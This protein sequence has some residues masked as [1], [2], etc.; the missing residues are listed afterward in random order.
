MYFI[1]VTPKVLAIGAFGGPKARLR[2][3]L[4]KRPVWHSGSE[5]LYHVSECLWEETYFIYRG[6]VYYRLGLS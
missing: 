1:I 4:L 2:M 3:G 5:P 6:D